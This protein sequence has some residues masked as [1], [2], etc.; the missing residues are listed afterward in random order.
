MNV[1]LFEGTSE[2]EKVLG[3]MYDLNVTEEDLA[4][5]GELQLPL[6]YG[7]FV[8]QI[9]YTF[10]SYPPPPPPSPPDHYTGD[11][12][13]FL[14]TFIMR[15]RNQALD[16][17]RAKLQMAFNAIE[18]K[19]RH[20]QMEIAKK[21]REKLEDETIA[22]L[23]TVPPQDRT[24]EQLGTL[25]QWL[26]RMKIGKDKLSHE[27]GNKEID[28][29]T[30]HLVAYTLPANSLLFIQGD[31]GSHYFWMIRGY[32]ELFTAFTAQAEFKLRS[33]YKSSKDTMSDPVEIE[34]STLGDLIATMEP[35]DGFGELSILSDAPRSLSAATSTDCVIC[36]IDT[37]T[38]MHSIS[39][40]HAEKMR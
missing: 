4:S 38:Y 39:S 40:I 37:D 30:R 12:K 31:E 15:W 22:I 34:R 23:C 8:G 17:T 21:E 5:F 18:A 19:M 3:T 16:K 2:Y 29:M 36:R 14:V 7:D 24:D 27:I 1:S 25:K 28:N 11:N 10:P 6:H 20:A 26:L 32:V 9:A 33:K 13:V 35:H